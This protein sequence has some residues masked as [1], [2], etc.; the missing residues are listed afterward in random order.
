MKLRILDGP[1]CC[2]VKGTLVDY[3]LV[4]GGACKSENMTHNVKEKR[5]FSWF[6][7][8]FGRGPKFITLTSLQSM[9]MSHL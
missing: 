4:S 5:S 3:L 9:N 7:K 8:V 6:N 1:H 2:E